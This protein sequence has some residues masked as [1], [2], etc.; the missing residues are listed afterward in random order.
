MKFFVKLLLVFLVLAAIQSCKN[1]STVV[2][3]TRYYLT[4]IVHPKYGTVE[5]D[6]DSVYQTP[7]GYDIKFTDVKFYLQDMK[8]GTNQILDA[9][10]FDYRNSDTLF[11]VEGNPEGITSL[12]A[13]L[14]V[15]A[16]I[17]HADPSAFP[18][19]SPL[20]IAISNDMHWGW[21]PGYIFVKIEAKAD[22]I[23]DGVPLFDHTI[24]YHVGLDVNLQQMNFS[25]I[26]WNPYGLEYILNF[27][28]DMQ[29]FLSGP[30]P[31]DVKT[32]Y[33]THSAAG[34]EVLTL[35]VAQNFAAALK[36]L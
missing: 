13:N 35:K 36:T 34:Q 12:T 21:S 3:V 5:L 19:D 31:I 9:A 7:E 2:D 22:T 15:D 32:E 23:A 20:N 16:S 1:D 33:T 24:V 30:Q 6:L 4:G 28:L 14:G 18:N 8:D 27:E 11:K 29:A 25:T 26:T 10:L 17:N